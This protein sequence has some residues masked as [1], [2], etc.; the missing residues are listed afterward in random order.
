MQKGFR[1]PQITAIVILSF[2]NAKF[3]PFLF[4]GFYHGAPNV[5]F[6]RNHLNGFS[7]CQFLSFRIAGET[8]VARNSQNPDVSG[9]ELMLEESVGVGCEAVT[10]IFNI[11]IASKF[12]EKANIAK[13]ARLYEEKF[14]GTSSGNPSSQTDQQP[15]GRGRGKG[16]GRGQ[17]KAQPVPHLRMLEPAPKV[18]RNSSPPTGSCAC[19]RRCVDST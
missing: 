4:L 15:R 14:R 9:L 17:P 8:A 1:N 3:Y 13:Q 7:S 2:E 16:K 6:C 10:T 11:W 5:L 18:S 12:K 19:F